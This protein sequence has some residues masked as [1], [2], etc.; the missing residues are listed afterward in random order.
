MEVGFVPGEVNKGAYILFQWKIKPKCDPVGNQQDK[1]FV[2]FHVAEGMTKKNK[3]IT[4]HVR[5]LTD[6]LFGWLAASS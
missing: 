6:R 2:P 1:K 3:F 4:Y 5:W